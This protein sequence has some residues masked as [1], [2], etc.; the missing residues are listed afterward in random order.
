MNTV[1]L[2][3]DLDRA[4]QDLNAQF[5]IAWN[6]A[7]RLG[8]S[9]A[10]LG[11]EFN[12]Q[13]ATLVQQDRLQRHDIMQSVGLIDEF[14]RAILDLNA[15]LQ[16]AWQEAE[17][18]GISTDKIHQEFARL[19]DEINRARE[20]RIDELALSITSP[21][22]QLSE[23]LREFQSELDRAL[24]NPKNQAASAQA[25]FRRIAAEAAAGNTEA[26]RQLEQAGQT[27]IEEMGRFG[28]S[29]AQAEAIKEVSAAVANAL[30]QV[31]RAR[32][33]A[34]SG[35]EAEIRLASQREVDT[36]YELIAEVR[37]VGEEI[38]RLRRV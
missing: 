8:I 3:S 2:M 27:Y 5:Q 22:E 13:A 23:P 17:R 28:A 19:A 6:E 20:A 33:E 9:T 7:E 30:S 12:R 4:L 14:D 31:E 36:L 18:L 38:K 16:I 26:I 37:L 34:E 10:K 29:P 1:G 32:I 11:R 35:F 24:L 21:F 15:N 25:E